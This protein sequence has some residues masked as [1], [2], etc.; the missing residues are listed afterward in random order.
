VATTTDLQQYDNPYDPS[1]QDFQPQTLPL[2]ELIALGLRKLELRLNVWRP[3]QVVNVRGNGRVDVQV[4]L[5]GQ[6]IN[7][8]TPFNLP[9]IQ[10]CLV[11]HLRGND[12]YDRPPI[13]VGD[14][15]I[16]MFCDRSLDAWSVQG[17]MVFPNDPRAHTLSDCAFVPGL[18]PFNN[19]II[20]TTTDLVRNNGLSNLR[21]RKDGGFVFAG[22]GLT[23][24]FYPTGAVTMVGG[25]MTAHFNANGTFFFSNGTNELVDLLSQMASEVQSFASTISTDTVNTMLGP[26]PLT[27][28]A[29]YANIASVLEDIYNKLLT[30]KGT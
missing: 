20:D 17:G 27:Q 30:L 4:L 10:D 16:A 9:V 23:V 13:A 21:M 26:Q 15:G 29:T 14:T 7:N 18:Y 24:T 11:N 12:Y 1:T 25:S 28:F 6:Y 3:A 2:D 8:P 5:Q 19:Q 22:G